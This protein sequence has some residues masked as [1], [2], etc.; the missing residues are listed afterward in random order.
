VDDV[1]LSGMD[2]YERQVTDLTVEGPSGPRG[3][4]GQEAPGLQFEMTA[5]VKAVTCTHTVSRAKTKQVAM[6]EK[7]CKD[8]EC[9]ERNGKIK[10]QNGPVTQKKTQRDVNRTTEMTK[11]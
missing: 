10:Q 11:D 8:H 1:R 3:S 4:K 6:Y 7:M 9:T 5:D 2:R